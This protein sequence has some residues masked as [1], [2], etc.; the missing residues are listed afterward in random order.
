M[1][2]NKPDRARF[3]GY[4]ERLRLVYRLFTLT[5]TAVVVE[6]PLLMQGQTHMMFVG[7]GSVYSVSTLAALAEYVYLCVHG[8]R[9]LRGRPILN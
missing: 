4:L 7:P 1:T 2:A 5:K 8:L 9:C 3:S 6:E